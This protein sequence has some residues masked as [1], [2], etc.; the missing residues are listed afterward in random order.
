M[1]LLHCLERP[2]IFSYGDLAILRGIRM[3]YH[4]RKVDKKLFEKY[5][6]RFSTYCSVA[7]IYFWAV[8]AGAIPELKDLGS[9]K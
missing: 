7:S 5:R 8:S 9:K 3:V 4:H 2:N 1:M 6:K